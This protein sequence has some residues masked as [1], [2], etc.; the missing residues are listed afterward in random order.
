[1]LMTKCTVTRLVA[2]AGLAAAGSTFAAT[3][4]EQS[5]APAGYTGVAPRHVDAVPFDAFGGAFN[6]G[7]GP[8]AM[9]DT[10]TNPAP[11]GQGLGALDRTAIVQAETTG[12]LTKQQQG[13]VAQIDAAWQTGDFETGRDFM[14]QLDATGFDGALTFAYTDTDIQPSGKAFDD[15]FTGE[16]RIGGARVAIDTFDLDVAPNGNMF[17]V[18]GWADTWTFNI[19]TDGGTTWT[20][21]FTFGVASPDVDL[22][23]VGGFVYVGYATTTGTEGRMRRFDP[24]TGAVDGGYFFQ[25][26]FT[27]VADTITEI[28]VE[29]NEDNFQNR[30]YWTCLTAN[31][32][33][34][35]FFDDS[36]DGTTF[37]TAVT[38]VTDGVG[39]LDLHWN[40]DFGTGNPFLVM[41]HR[42]A[43]GDAVAT[44]N[45]GSWSS[46]SVVS[47]AGVGDDVNISAYQDTIIVAYTSPLGG[48]QPLYEISYDG[49]ATYD[50]S[51]QIFPAPIVGNYRKADVAAA[52]GYGTAMIA[53]EEV[54]EPDPVRF[55]QR[56]FYGPGV[57]S[58]QIAN[59]NQTDLQTGR[60][61]LIEALPVGGS[62]TARYGVIHV[63]VG[64]G[65]SFPVFDRVDDVACPGD[66][67]NDFG[68]PGADGM[69]SFG[70]FLALVG[71]VGPCGPATGN[72]ACIGD[73][74]DDF[75]TPGGDGMVSFGDFLFM[76]GVVGPCP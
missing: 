14:A 17:A 49:G 71:L 76:V 68:T 16:R 46:T 44:V 37:G 1:M 41:S 74:A 20:E 25:T 28:A 57:W 47:G 27:P 11:T 39:P 2:V 45:T 63:T 32:T 61:M 65:G 72:P 8:F 48:S 23:Y 35:Y 10:V 9:P 5:G 60:D 3:P 12:E 24:A 6:P 75:G 52:L 51:G 43:A 34:E 53:G 7:S 38:N 19:S 64:A 4:E 50:L 30:I 29:S 73:N 40:Q 62:V 67:A 56:P 31:G 36:A 22:A 13:L 58:N 26:I 54:G 33:I 70:D 66:I 69:V 18:T 21:T 15:V 42:N 59:T 55:E